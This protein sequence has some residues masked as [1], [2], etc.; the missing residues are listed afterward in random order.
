MKDS[1]GNRV[2]VLLLCLAAVPMVAVA[3][4]SAAGLY[5]RGNAKRENGDVAG[6]IADYTR[7]IELDPKYVDAYVRRAVV[8]HGQGDLTGAIADY[9][10]AI[11]IDPK[12]RI[13]YFNRGGARKSNGDLEGSLSDISKSIELEPKN[14]FG[15]WARGELYLLLGKPAD[16]LADYR[17]CCEIADPAPDYPHL[18]I[19]LIRTRAGEKEAADKEFS[20]YLATRHAD[21]DKFFP[22]A[23]GYLLGT[24]SEA[25][26]L[27]SAKFFIPDLEARQKAQ[28]SYYMGMK[29]LLAGDKEGAAACFNK[30]VATGVKDLSER[31]LSAAE[32][33]AL[34]K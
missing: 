17:R 22:A 29:K 24:V 21:S 13:A 2:I 15:Y 32:L 4:D 8:K 5:D 16:A 30:C 10:N 34:G 18:F 6:A 3:Q 12:S 7:A 25:D 27:A 14:E 31:Q 26:M 28:A 20:D 23:A 33:K 11:A 9:T 1:F 19:W